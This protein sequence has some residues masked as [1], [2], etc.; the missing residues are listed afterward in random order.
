M[1]VEDRLNTKMD[2][3]DKKNKSIGRENE[4]I[5]EIRKELNIEH[6]SCYRS[7]MTSF[8]KQK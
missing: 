2:K 6:Y 8:I 3:I 7:G 1:D 5:K 4:S